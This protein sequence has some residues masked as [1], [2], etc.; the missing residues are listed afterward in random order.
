MLEWQR[1]PAWMIFI[2][3]A[4]AIIPLAGWLGRAT[5]H[6]AVH[7]GEG[8]G[9]LL[10]ATLG[11]TAELI[12]GLMALRE[13]LYEVVKASLTGSIIGNILLVLGLSMLAGG[14]RYPEQHFSPMGASLGATMLTLAAIGL[15]VPAAFAHLTLRERFP[16]TQELSAAIALILMLTYGISLLFSLRT[17]KHLFMGRAGELEGE[18]PWSLRKAIGVLIASAV[19]IAVCSEFLVGTVEETTRQLRLS[20][21][22][23]GVIIVALVGNAAEHSSAIFLAR[24]NKMDLSLNIAIGSSLQIALFVGPLLVLLSYAFGP[25]MDLVFTTVEVLAVVVSVAIVDLV[26]LDGR[27]HWFEGV[28]LLSVYLILAIVFYFLPHP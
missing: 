22:F 10:N 1:G 27:S 28:Q 6:L 12:I 20:E 8:V 17:H 4:L 19:G 21:I 14:L 25:P 15:V 23:V 5:E 26:A 7:A 16:H 24:K 13:G 3:S 18:A 2:A 11:N 9:G